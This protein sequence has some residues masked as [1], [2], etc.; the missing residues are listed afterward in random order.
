MRGKV[1]DDRIPEV[2]HCFHCPDWGPNVYLDSLA[3]L[4]A[5]QFHDRHCHRVREVFFTAELRSLYSIV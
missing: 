3:K 5:I 4:K 1:K 2:S